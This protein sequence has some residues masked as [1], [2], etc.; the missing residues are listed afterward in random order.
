MRRNATDP[1]PTQWLEARA[2]PEPV[3]GYCSTLEN[4][5]VEALGRQRRNGSYSDTLPDELVGL[6]FRGGYLQRALDGTNYR[7]ICV[8]PSGSP[9]TPGRLVG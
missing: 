6:C 8:V 1:D 2:P 7:V 3:R 9:V 4:I 5:D